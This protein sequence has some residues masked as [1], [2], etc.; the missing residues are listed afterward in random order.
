MG[1]TFYEVFAY[2][3]PLIKLP[4]FC[5]F[6]VN[7]LIWVGLE[8]SQDECGATSERDS[9]Q[10][11]TTEEDYITAQLQEKAVCPHQ[12]PARVLRRDNWGW[13]YAIHVSSYL[14][15]PSLRGCLQGH[16]SYLLLTKN[17][18]CQTKWKLWKLWKSIT[19]L[20]PHGQRNIHNY[21]IDLKT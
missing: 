21:A 6:P 4:L 7:Q 5:S 17:M 15:N 20:W 14:H 2:K 10:A 8:M 11:F 16:S 13:F 19:A 18:F 12:E 1:N 3:W 9:H